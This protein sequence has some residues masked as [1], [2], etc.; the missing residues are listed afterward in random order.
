MKSGW[1]SASQT[2]QKNDE[3]KPRRNSMR[4]HFHDHCCHETKRGKNCYHTR[5]TEKKAPIATQYFIM[6]TL[7]PSVRLSG[8]AP[9]TWRDPAY[10]VEQ[11]V[12]RF[13]HFLGSRRFFILPRTNQLTGGGPPPTSESSGFAGPPF[14]KHHKPVQG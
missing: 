2:C 13:M 10:I 7:S 11:K 8:V 14:G 3:P 12:E 4:D 9:V 5:S 6:F 1:Q